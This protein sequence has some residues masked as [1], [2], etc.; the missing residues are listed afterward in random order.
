MV[1]D[2]R[3]QEVVREL[4]IHFAVDL[5]AFVL[6]NCVAVKGMKAP[7]CGSCMSPVSHSR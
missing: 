2:A 7:R 4:G 1:E 6:K 5:C 3:A